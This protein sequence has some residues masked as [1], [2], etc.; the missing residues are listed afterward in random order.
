MVYMSEVPHD[1]IL[2]E[3]YTSKEILY[4]IGY[5]DVIVLCEETSMFTERSADK[6]FVLNI[7]ET[8]VHR[9]DHGKSYNVPLKKKKVYVINKVR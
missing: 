1:L 8:F 3:T 9:N 2:G 6:Y 5:N 4:F 7:Y